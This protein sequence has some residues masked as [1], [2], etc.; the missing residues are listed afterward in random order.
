MSEEETTEEVKP[1][2]F[3]YV[4]KSVNMTAFG[5]EFRKDGKGKKC[6]VTEAAVIAKLTGNPY[7]HGDGKD[8]YREKAETEEAKAKKM[9]AAAAKNK[10]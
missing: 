9:K 4:G 5:Y 3:E 1:Q 8:D 10:G 6:T 2:K 7:F